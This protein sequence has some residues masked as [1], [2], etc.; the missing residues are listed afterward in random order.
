MKTI[1]LV[2]LF[3]SPFLLVAELLA[4]STITELLRQPSDMAV[5]VGV[6]GV[7]IFLALNYFLINKLIKT[8]NQNE[9][10]NPNS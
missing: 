4:F 7:C 9:K 10:A 3:L 5:L 8:I 2:Y 6:L 1:Y